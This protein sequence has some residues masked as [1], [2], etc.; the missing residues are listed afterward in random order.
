MELQKLET[1]PPRTYAGNWLS[2]GT[3]MAFVKITYKNSYT[4]L[5]K[6]KIHIHYKDEVVNSGNVKLSHD[7][8]GQT[9][10]IP[11]VW[12]SQNFWTIGILSWWSCQT[13]VPVSFIP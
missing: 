13:Y 6:N 4:I 7:K 9:R 8:P 5:Q 1:E 3:A 11:G 2:Q 12:S 10:K